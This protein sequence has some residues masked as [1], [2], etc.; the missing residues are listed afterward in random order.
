METAI[1]REKE[2]K[3][4]RRKKKEK[5]VESMDP[6]R[7]DRAADWYPKGLMK[8]GVPVGFSKAKT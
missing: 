8:D 3:S 4:W 5:L 7:K 6:S 1:A 2:I